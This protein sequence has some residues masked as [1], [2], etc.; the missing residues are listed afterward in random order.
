MLVLLFPELEATVHLVQESGRQHKD[1]WNHTRQVVKHSIWPPII[2]GKE[3]KP[4]DRGIMPENI[5]EMGWEA[6]PEGIY[7]LLKHFAAYKGV[8]QII[9]TENGAAFPDRLENGTVDDQRR[10]RYY[11]EYLTQVLR[12]KNEGVP[13]KGY[14]CWT[15]MD[16][17]EWAEGYKPRFGLVYVD[18]A[19][20]Q[21]IVK[22]SGLWFRDFL[23]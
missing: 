14:F 8:R 7:H 13:V 23:K 21:R 11:Q 22:K 19:T 1:V 20:Q 12:A 3:I 16:N 18:F 17:F 15:L 4:A 10:L 6:Y 9:V 2:W 5:T